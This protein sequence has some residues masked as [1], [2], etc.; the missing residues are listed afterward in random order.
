MK[1]NKFGDYISD[2]VLPIKRK[3]MVDTDRV[4]SPTPVVCKQECEGIHI[5]T[6]WHFAYCKVLSATEG[7]DI[8]KDFKFNSE[9]ESKSSAAT[10]RNR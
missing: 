2:T 8:L 9:A 7:N 5:P 1:K 10:S 6:L 4:I 3:T